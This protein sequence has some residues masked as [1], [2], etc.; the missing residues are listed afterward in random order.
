MTT[1]GWYR[2]KY[3]LPTRV[4]VTRPLV[5]RGC[6]GSAYAGLTRHT[7]HV[8]VKQTYT[9]GLPLLALLRQSYFP[10]AHVVITAGPYR[11]VVMRA[12]NAHLRLET[13]AEIALSVG[14]QRIVVN[15]LVKPQDAGYHIDMNGGVGQRTTSDFDW[16]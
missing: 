1:S 15:T 8:E 5:A 7:L 14:L 2:K 3:P 12:W 11:Y 9:G 13:E 10:L 6:G 16:P 4:Y